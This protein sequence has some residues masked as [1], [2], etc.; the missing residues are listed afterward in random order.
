MIQKLIEEKGHI[1]LF[2]PKFYCKLNSI[3][4]YWGF[5]KFR[6]RDL[7]DGRFPS[8]KELV[9]CISAT[10]WLEKSLPNEPSWT[11]PDTVKLA[12]I[13][14]AHGVDLL[15]VSSAGLHPAQRIVFEN[16]DIELIPVLSYQAPLSG[17]VR[18]VNG[19]DTPTGLL[20]GVVGEIKTGHVAE[21]TLQ[22][23]LSDVAF[24]GRQ[25]LRDP[26]AV[27]TF[28][29]QLGIKTKIAH[30]FAWGLGYASSGR[31]HRAR[32]LAKN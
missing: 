31:G 16:S 2:L 10:D 8:A 12:G 26:A 24:V 28:A 13:L 6:Y 21:E 3:K 23:G 30:Q 19:V 27:L 11:V 20:V 7:N 32:A 25:F 1:C 17:A 15:D 14:A 29:E 5:G 4:L 18:K 22:Q 9:P